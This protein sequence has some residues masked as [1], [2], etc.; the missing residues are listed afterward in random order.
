MFPA[1]KAD[2]VGV[3][4]VRDGSRLQPENGN[5][6][7][8]YLAGGKSLKVRSDN[9]IFYGRAFEEKFAAFN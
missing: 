1:D 9:G 6:G 4:V 5:Y 3:A 2:G 7:K 8:T